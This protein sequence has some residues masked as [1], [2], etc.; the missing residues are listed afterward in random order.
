MVWP[1]TFYFGFTLYFLPFFVELLQMWWPQT[2]WKVL[3]T[4][5]TFYFRIR[6]LIGNANYLVVKIIC[7]SRLE[8]SCRRFRNFRKIYLHLLIKG[9]DTKSLRHC[10]CDFIASDKDEPS[11]YVDSKLILKYMWCWWW[12]CI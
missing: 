2:F 4:V 9:N 10:N 8:I 6:H 5:Y 7:G 3:Y 11:C 1:N 12:S